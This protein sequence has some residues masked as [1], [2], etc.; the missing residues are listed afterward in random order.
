MNEDTLISVHCYQ[1]DADLVAR[2][3]PVHRAHGYR[4][5]ICSPED[6]IVEFPGVDSIVAGK[7]AYIGALS[8]TRQHEHLKALLSYPHKYFLLNDADSFCVSAKIPERIY[9]EAENTLWS[10]EVTEPRPHASPYP[11]IAAQPPYFLTRESIQKMLEASPRVAVHPITPYL[12]YAMLAWACEAGMQ[13][14]AFTELEHASRAAE[15][16]TGN[17]SWTQLSYR[18]RY[19]GTCF[20]HPIKTAEQLALCVN[21]RKF[22]ESS[23]R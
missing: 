18:I 13:H 11:K 4:V 10:N 19:C 2:A 20:C 9:A 8:W 6:S 5:V 16:Y 17:D 3:L 7:R 14:R 22:Y 15:P 1:G 23:E 21:A 12:D